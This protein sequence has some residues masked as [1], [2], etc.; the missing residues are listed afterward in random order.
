MEALPNEFAEA[1]INKQYKILGKNLHSYCLYDVLALHAIESPVIV[2][3]QLTLEELEKAV[4]ICSTPLPANQMEAAI[5]SDKIARLFDIK[6]KTWLQKYLLKRWHKKNEKRY[7]PELFNFRCFLEDYSTFPKIHSELKGAGNGAN[8]V[9]ARAGFYIY[10]TGASVEYTFSLPIGQLNHLS[11]YFSA[12]NSGKITFIE[13]VAGK[14][15][16]YSKILE[17]IQRGEIS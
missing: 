7:A 16:K 8:H 13:E 3:G 5:Y 1:W 4:L 12:L 10:Q 14:I 6:S 17:A 9:L 2:G 15:E 11:T